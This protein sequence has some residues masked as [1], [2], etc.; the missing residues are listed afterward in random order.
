MK[1]FVRLMSIVLALL[2]VACLAVSCATPGDDS[3]GTTTPT[4]SATTPA[5]GDTSLDSQT[6]N[7]Y[8][9]KNNLPS[10]LQF[11]GQTVRILSRDSDGVRDEIAVNDYIGEPVNDAIYERNAAV[12]AQLG[13]KISNT[14]LTGGNYVVTEKVRNL[15][16]K[17]VKVLC[18]ATR[19]F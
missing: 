17:S 19:F 9:V 5:D 16:P 6:E 1:T 4:A 10:D 7:Q 13:I 2:F 18:D 11:P 15:V 8:D 14:K 12:E 3:S